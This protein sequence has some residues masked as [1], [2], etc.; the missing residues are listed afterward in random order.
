MT[1]LRFNV[2][3][4]IFAVQ[5]SGESWQVYSVGSDGKLGHAGIIIPDFIGESELEQYF[6]DIFHES[7]RPGMSDVRRIS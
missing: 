7:A 4:R 1:L 3:G 2:F 5:R 6:A